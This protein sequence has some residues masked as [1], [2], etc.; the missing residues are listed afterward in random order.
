[1]RDIVLDFVKHIT[2]ENH[3]LMWLVH[4]K[5]VSHQYH[6]WFD[7][8]ARNANKFF[9]LFGTAFQDHMKEEVKNDNTL[10]S[11]IQ[12]FIEIGR[13]RNRLVHGDFGNFSL[14]KTSEEIYMLYVKAKRFVE[15]FPEALKTFAEEKMLE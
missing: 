7:W 4:N 12:A 1:M 15:W 6:T 13:E 5:A 2:T 3:P 14:E 9:G 8:E 10:S 11:S